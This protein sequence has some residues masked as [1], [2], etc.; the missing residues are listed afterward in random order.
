[1]RSRRRRRGAKRKQQ[2]AR[3]ETAQARKRTLINRVIRQTIR[4]AMGGRKIVVAPMNVDD[5]RNRE[6]GR[7][8]AERLKRRKVDISAI[9][10]A[11]RICN[12]EWEEGG[13]IIYTTASRRNDYALGKRNTN[14]IENINGI[15]RIAIVIKKDLT[16]N[17]LEI[18]R[19][20]ERIMQIILNANIRGGR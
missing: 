4:I 15:W 5:L 11:H 19:T 8:I 1:M 12:G 6:K 3:L 18:T 16:S 14:N 17:I 7:V 20:N 2:L 13:Y 10:E 9:H